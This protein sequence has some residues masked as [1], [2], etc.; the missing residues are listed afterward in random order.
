MMKAIT[1]SRLRP[2]NFETDEDGP[3]F[4]HALRNYG[5][6]EQHNNLARGPDARLAKP[7]VALLRLKPERFDANDGYRRTIFLRYR[8]E[9]RNPAF[10]LPTVRIGEDSH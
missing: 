5:S 6:R 1:E 10:R 4:V 9:I 2:G 7:P 8:K 3:N